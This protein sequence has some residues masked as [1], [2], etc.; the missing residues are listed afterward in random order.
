[1]P[2]T[3]PQ[4]RETGPSGP[5]EDRIAWVTGA[6]SGI[7]EALVHALDR[8]GARVV[9][10]ARREERLRA[11]RDAC[12]HPDRHLVVP[13]DLGDPGSLEAAA[14]RVLERLG[15]V[16]L[17]IHN[18][19][20]SQRSLAEETDPAVDRRLL[21]INFLGP[22]TLTKAVLPSMLER[23]EGDEHGGDGGRIVVI[24][25]L[26]GTFGTPLRSAYSASKHA[27]HGFFESL[28]AEVADRGVRVTMICPG[29][30]RTD[31]SVNALTGD[32]SPQGT[33]DRAQ[34]RGMAP[35]ECAR[36]ILRAVER[37]QAEVLVGGKERFAVHLKRWFPG[38]FRW[39]IRRV[40]VT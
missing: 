4:Q 32:G 9:L 28:A 38:V 37:G 27:L 7:G 14:H 34:A 31:V 30:I 17:L 15:R 24:S 12:E 11:V 26:V 23:G 5:F 18:G 35:E 20:V 10:S 36:R 19:G 21:D 16:D 8:R 13:L 6:S 29:F 22:V 1:M 40:K 3:P 25:S 39:L 2:R 33:M